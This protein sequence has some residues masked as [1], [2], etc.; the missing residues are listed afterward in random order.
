MIIL[1][2]ILQ[3]RKL[4]MRALNSNYG[5]GKLHFLKVFLVLHLN[6]ASTC[7]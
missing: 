4:A 3:D 7:A 6:Q 5:V 2:A 1:L